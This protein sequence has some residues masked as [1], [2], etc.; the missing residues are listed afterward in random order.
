MKTV[1]AVLVAAVF[2]SGSAFAQAKPHKGNG[3][4]PD[5]P[6]APIAK[7]C[8]AAGFKVGDHKN[9]KGL[10]LDCVAKIAGGE[11]VAGVTVGT[12]VDLAGCKA[13]MEERKANHEAKKEAKK[14]AKAAAQ[15]S[16]PAESA[17]AAPAAN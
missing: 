7:A 3:H 6:C 5:G 4:H 11:T 1:F 9:G 12:D 13:K 14:E 16:K 15:G 2:A 17:S 8:H 10:W